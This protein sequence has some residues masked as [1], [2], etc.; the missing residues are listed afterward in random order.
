MEKLY[1][2]EKG[3]PVD[4]F[5]VRQAIEEMSRR[6]KDSLHALP[7]DEAREVLTKVMQLRHVRASN[8]GH[9]QPPKVLL[10][11][12]LKVVHKWK[13][14]GEQGLRQYG[15]KARRW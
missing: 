8:A 2:H 14:E 7:A 5:K 6:R 3:V 13:G 11:H 12:E 15:K 1:Q 4:R 10:P 9:K